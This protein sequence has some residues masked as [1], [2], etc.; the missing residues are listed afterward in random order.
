MNCTWQ[1]IFS[2]HPKPRNETP[3][4]SVSPPDFPAVITARAPIHR[5]HADSSQSKTASPKRRRQSRHRSGTI[6]IVNG[7]FNTNAP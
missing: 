1:A 4:L 5:H 3:I 2:V 7:H 6:R